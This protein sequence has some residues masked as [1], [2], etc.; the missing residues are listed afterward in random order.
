[1]KLTSIL[2]AVSIMSLGL[3]ALWAPAAEAVCHRR[4]P[5]CDCPEFLAVEVGCST[6]PWAE[7]AGVQFSAV[8]SQDEGTSGAGTVAYQ[9]AWDQDPSEAVPFTF[10]VRGSR[11]VEWRDAQDFTYTHSNETQATMIRVFQSFTFTGAPEDV[12]ISF[13]V[14]AH[15]GT[16]KQESLNGTVA[17]EEEHEEREKTVFDFWPQMLVLLGAGLLVGMLVQR[18]MTRKM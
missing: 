15:P 11:G 10:S 14:T 4:F 8:A 17:F 18:R 16:A 9:F 13:T 7:I 12:V 3:V 6:L 1:V 2:V 5:P